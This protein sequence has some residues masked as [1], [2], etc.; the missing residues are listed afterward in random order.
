M[1]NLFAFIAM[2]AFFLCKIIYS[3]QSLRFKALE[4]LAGVDSTLTEHDGKITDVFGSNVFSGKV[5]RE[6][7]SDEAYKSLMNSVK[8]GTKLERKMSE[9]I[10][11]GMKAWAMKKV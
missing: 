3:M 5:V 6:Y 9:Q 2:D 1:N 10:A 4:G 11:S 8:N 7:L